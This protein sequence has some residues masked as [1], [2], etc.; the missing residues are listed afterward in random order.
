MMSFAKDAE[1][2]VIAM[3]YLSAEP[4]PAQNVSKPDNGIQNV[5]V[6]HYDLSAAAVREQVGEIAKTCLEMSYLGKKDRHGKSGSD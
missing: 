4:A 6:L 1:Y 5:Y 2:M 3:R